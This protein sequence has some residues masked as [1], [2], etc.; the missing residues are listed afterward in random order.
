MILL[1]IETSCDETAVALVEATGDFPH[2]KYRVLGNGLL[3][4]IDIHREFGGVFPAVAKREHAKAL[5]PMLEKALREAGM[6]S[7]KEISLSEEIE[8]QLNILLEREPTLAEL[9]IE[10]FKTHERPAINA[11][12]VTNGPGLAPAL[13]VGVNFA[14]ALSAHWNI[15]V[16]PV[17]HMEGHIL[18]SVFEGDHLGTMHFP[19]LALLIS[20]GHTEF[21]LMRDF[22][23]YEKIGSTLDDAVG[24]AFDKTAR[25]L[26]LPYPGGPEIAR[27][28]AHARAENLP[29][30]LPP[31]PRPMLH[32]PDFNVSFSGLKTAVRTRVLDKE[33]TDDEQAVVARDFEDAATEVLIKKA[34]R[35]LAHTN[36]QTLIL[37]G[38]V[39][40]NT[41]IRNAFEA[42]VA[43]EFPDINLHLPDRE[44]STDNAIMIALSGH[45]RLAEASTNTENLVANG[46]L[47]L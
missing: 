7:E 8:K 1:S 42:L 25:M 35:A 13:W 9:L 37:G 14:R 27:L 16:I 12:A 40:A 2:A 39:T 47:S 26:G 32:T 29:P 30:L 31:L 17:N 21:V 19:A 24:E 41:N 3:S 10:F 36:A 28:A 11:I 4:Q 6:L 38:G 5:V 46:G 45:A 15:P 18:S 44:L 22:A 34:T 33:L 23:D 43:K 20:G